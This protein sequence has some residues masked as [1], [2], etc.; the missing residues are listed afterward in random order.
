MQNLFNRFTSH[1]PLFPRI[2]TPVICAAAL[3]LPACATPLKP[4]P[5]PV[6]QAFPPGTESDAWESLRRNL[7][8]LESSS[9]FGIVDTGAED[10]RW[11]LAMIDTARVSLDFQY[12]LWLDDAVGALLFER[13]LLAADRGVRVRLLVDDS[14]LS[15]EDPVVLALDVHPNVEVRIYN[16][17]QLRS[18]NMLVRYLD[19]L[20][21]F[22]RTNHR[23][24]NKLIVADTEVAIV[25]G[26]NIAD[27][28]FGF[29]TALNFR[30]FGVI[31]TGAIVPAL[32][33][34]FDVYWNSGWAF[35][36]TAVDQ[37]QDNVDDL[38][39][40]RQELRA[41]DSI[42][43]GWQV[44]AAAGLHD[45]SGE[46]AALGRSMLPGEAE[47]LQDKPHFEGPTPPELVASRVRGVIRQSDDEILG[48]SAYLVPTPS[49]VETIREQ[50]ERGVRIR[51]LTNS[52]AS[53][54]HVPA[55]AAYRH[56]R[57][58]L[59][60]AGAEL[61][62]FRPDGLDRSQYEV[63]GFMAEQF[64]LHGK[65][66]I[67]DDDRVFI[68][69]LNLDPRSMVLN[70]EI[71]LLIHSAAVNAAVREAFAPNFSLDNSWRVEQD[72]AGELVWRSHDGVLTLQP[73]GGFWR[74]VADFF[75]GLFPI[76]SQM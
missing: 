67:F 1:G 56:H 63:P 52:L 75:Y 11:R 16:P 65:V 42:L 22:G 36:V 43:D 32:A 57:K 7:P 31:T 28:Y 30:D 20:N 76:D 10:L 46:W 33:G 27:E 17:Y 73:A 23:M 24:H 39:A 9:W 5:Q 66:L 69:T 45:W 18:E 21:D 6:S 15:G 53:T 59:V 49:L 50:N 25:G 26:R 71:G 70:T 40:L 13:L 51:L 4:Q 2:I 72:E 47:M 74:R 35:P 62:V 41:R 55:H 19:N 37:Q 12:F 64:G 68:G 34:G 54:N 44:D 48:I 14:F 60:K 61:Y 38:R 8:K 29:G 3:L 58:Q